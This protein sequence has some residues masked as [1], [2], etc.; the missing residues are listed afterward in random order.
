MPTLDEIRNIKQEDIQG[1]V[2]AIYGEI[3][4][5][6]AEIDF[7]FQ[8]IEIIRARCKHPNTGTRSA[9]GKETWKV[10]LDCGKEL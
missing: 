7:Y 1:Q 10:C 3:A 4:T 2:D 5:L 8:I 6:R 9:M